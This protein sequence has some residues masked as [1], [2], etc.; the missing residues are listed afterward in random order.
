MNLV[1][2]IDNILVHF[3]G[4]NGEGICILDM[5]G[6]NIVDS[7][8]VSNRDILTFSVDDEGDLT[9]L[10]SSLDLGKDAIKS[11][12]EVFKKKVNNLNWI[13]SLKM[14]SYFILILSIEI[15]Y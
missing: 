7:S 11:H 10:V 6:G 3:K 13:R 2:N 1:E 5:E 4:T 14:K 8:I 15:R 9:Y 12:V